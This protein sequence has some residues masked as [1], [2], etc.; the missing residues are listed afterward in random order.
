[1]IFKKIFAAAWHV[2]DVICFLLALSAFCY[3]AFLLGGTP[4]LFIIAGIA[5]CLVGFGVELIS[6][7]QKGGD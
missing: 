5:L 3:A 4:W 7:N 1:M 2:I 6:G